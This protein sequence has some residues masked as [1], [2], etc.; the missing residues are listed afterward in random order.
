MRAPTAT[1]RKRSVWCRVIRW[2]TVRV[3][4]RAGVSCIVPLLLLL[5]SKAT[6]TSPACALGHP[7]TS[8]WQP[9]VLTRLILILLHLRWVVRRRDRIALWCDVRDPLGIEHLRR[10]LRRAVHRVTVWVP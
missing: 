1:L 9:L 3:A 8:L 7:T 4:R 6:S 10:K 5:L 2:L